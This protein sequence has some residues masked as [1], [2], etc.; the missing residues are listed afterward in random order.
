MEQYR[1]KNLRIA[2]RQLARAE[3]QLAAVDSLD[4]ED[5]EAA[6]KVREIVEHLRGLRSYTWARDRPRM[7]AAARKSLLRFRFSTGASTPL[8]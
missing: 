5:D 8:P 3:L 6:R 1:R 7:A 4:I 2:I